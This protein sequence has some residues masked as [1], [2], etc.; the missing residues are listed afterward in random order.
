MLDS[1]RTLYVLPVTGGEEREAHLIVLAVNRP[2]VSGLHLAALLAT[3]LDRR[4]VHGLYTAGPDRVE[5]CVIDGL[6]QRDRPLSQLR[7]PRSA[8]IDAAVLQALML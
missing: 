7:Q 2:E 4:L 5:L 1:E 6:Q 3:G 8:D